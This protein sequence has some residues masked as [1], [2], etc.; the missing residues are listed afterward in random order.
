MKDMFE[1]NGY[2]VKVEFTKYFNGNTAIHLICDDL[3]PYMMVTVNIPN[4]MNSRFALE[5]PLNQVA[6][7]NYSEGK[8]IEKVLIEAGIIEDKPIKYV[9]SGF[10]DIPIYEITKEACALRDSYFVCL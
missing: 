7:K 9:R 10:V 8:G 1:I 6:I 3:S 4:P 5:L 2:K